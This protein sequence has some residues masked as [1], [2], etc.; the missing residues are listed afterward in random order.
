MISK[1]S[2]KDSYEIDR[3]ILLFYFL[4]DNI[5]LNADGQKLYLA[6]FGNAIKMNYGIEQYIHGDL[7]SI[8]YTVSRM[9]LAPDNPVRLPDKII[10]V[11]WHKCFLGT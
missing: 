7:D 8:K 6:D 9:I 10:I 3:F 1:V 11:S 4:A 2:A 5:L